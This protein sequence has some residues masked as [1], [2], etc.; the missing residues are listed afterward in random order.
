[1]NLEERVT[2][3]AKSLLEA[4]GDDFLDRALGS[5]LGDWLD[6]GTAFVL[7]I[8]KRYGRTPLGDVLRE[9]LTRVSTVLAEEKARLATEREE[10]DLISVCAACGTESCWS[11]SRLCPKGLTAGTK[12]IRRP[13]P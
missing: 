6:A 2:Q 5:A 9:A 8:E 11:G 13:K 3:E 10:A 4:L 7:V 1:M 12:K